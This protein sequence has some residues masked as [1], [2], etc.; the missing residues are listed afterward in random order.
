VFKTEREADLFD[1]AVIHNDGLV[2]H[3]DDKYEINSK[4]I[5]TTLGKKIYSTDYVETDADY[6][7]GSID[8]A[9]QS[10]VSHNNPLFK[11]QM[12]EKPSMFQHYK[13]DKCYIIDKSVCITTPEFNKYEKD[14]NII[15]LSADMHKFF[16]GLNNVD[17]TLFHSSYIKYH[18]QQMDGRYRVD[19]L[20][21]AWDDIV[22][23][24][25]IA[26][27]LKDGSV[28]SGN[29]IDGRPTMNT[30]VYVLN[31]E[32]FK[33]CLDWNVAKVKMQ[34]EEIVN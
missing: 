10:I 30:F 21:T 17:Y 12:I 31:P 7:T 15:C 27:R 3:T 25:M 24:Q 22:M 19:L 28:H 1:R 8:E 5:Q 26:P 16:D 32:T 33:F 20:L 2:L 4:C 14:P 29:D 11:Y 23:N 13:P 34:W 18:N 6:P 9:P